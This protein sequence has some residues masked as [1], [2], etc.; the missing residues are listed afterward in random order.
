MNRLPQHP[1]TRP[2]R[3]PKNPITTSFFHAMDL[4]WVNRPKSGP[5]Q[6]GRITTLK[7]GRLALTFLY[8]SFLMTSVTGFSQKSK[9]SAPV[10][11]IFPNTGFDEVKI[12]DKMDVEL[13]FGAEDRLVIVTKPEIFAKLNV[14]QNQG[15]LSLSIKRGSR[16]PAR[17]DV[18]VFLTVS[19]IKSIQVANL[20]NLLVMN[21]VKGK[22]IDL[23]VS[24][25][26]TLHAPLQVEH[27][28]LNVSGASM[29]HLEGFAHQIDSQLSG[30]SKLTDFQFLCQKLTGSFSGQS[31]AEISVAEKITYTG[32]GGSS[33]KYKGNASVEAMGTS[34]D[35]SVSRADS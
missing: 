12:S 8:V 27:L 18:K 15:K 31:S 17:D 30:N 16:L 10:E 24:G 20:S 14:D 13:T 34:G 5:F 11:K 19:K 2:Q 21:T 6:N 32:S 33:L 28:N 23:N 22:E 26:S 3:F 29:V 4:I 35:S 9:N 7:S 1:D 25:G